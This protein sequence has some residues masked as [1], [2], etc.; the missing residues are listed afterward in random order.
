MALGD[1]RR[2]VPPKGLFS[3]S[4]AVMLWFLVFPLFGPQDKLAQSIVL[5]EGIGIGSWSKDELLGRWVYSSITIL[6]YNCIIFYNVP[7]SFILQI[8]LNAQNMLCCSLNIFHYLHFINKKTEA[9]RL[10]NLYLQLFS[11]PD[12][13]IHIQIWYLHLQVPRHFKPLRAE[14]NSWSSAVSDL[15]S[16]VLV[17]GTLAKNPGVSFHLLHPPYLSSL[18]F[19][20]WSPSPS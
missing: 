12:A 16:T 7:S 2:T 11:S 1:G 10:P 4:L 17:S 5:W 8:P 14:R 3:L 19:L 18:E 13:Q 15:P 9:Q 20:S 6:H